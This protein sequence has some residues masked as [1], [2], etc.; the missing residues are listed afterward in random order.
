M[1]GLIIWLSVISTICVAETT[2]I[3]ILLCKQKKQNNSHTI[4]LKFCELEDLIRKTDEK[5]ES[6]NSST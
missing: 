2:L 3:V 5:I 4:D 6:L 1:L